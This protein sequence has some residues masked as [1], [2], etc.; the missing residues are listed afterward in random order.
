MRARRAA[1]SSAH[2][3]AAGQAIAERIATL[4]A[5][6]AARHVAGYGAVG[7]EPPVASLAA[8]AI[9]RGRRWYLPTLVGDSGFMRFAPWH[10]ASPMAPNRYAI[11]EPVVP[12]DQLVDGCDLDLVL[13]PLVAFDRSGRR[14]GSGGGFYDRTFAFLA[15]RPRPGRPLLI[16]IAWAF[17]EATIEPEPW[18]IPVDW[19]AT[20]AELIRCH[21]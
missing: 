12:A 6:D 1:T 18:D 8:T 10:P 2:R 3:E 17:Q 7:G 15:D 20:E 14:L 13:V 11:P 21:A 19:V 16:G 4:P 9:A 5:F